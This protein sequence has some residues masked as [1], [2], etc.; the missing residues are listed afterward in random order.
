MAEKLRKNRLAVLLLVTG[1]V[2]F[3][4][5]VIAPLTAPI[6]IAMLFVTIFG[7]LLQKLQSRLHLHRQICAV[8]LLL[9]WPTLNLM[10]RLQS[11]LAEHLPGGKKKKKKKRPAE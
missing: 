3:F 6:L 1:A 7:P 5:K 8:F 4:L 10:Y 11:R 9:A 2:Y